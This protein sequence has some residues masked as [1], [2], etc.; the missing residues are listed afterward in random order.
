[1]EIQSIAVLGGGNGAHALAA[2]LALQGYEVYMYELPEFAEKFQ[3]TLKSQS[4]S[5]APVF[6]PELPEKYKVPQG[7]AR[8]KKATTNIKEALE[9][10][11]VIIV[12][13]PAYGHKAFAETLAP[14]IRDGQIILLTPG[15]LGS[16][17]FRN[18]FKKKGITTNVKIA[19]TAILPYG[20]R[21]TG[22][23]EVRAIIPI[24]VRFAAY[25][26]RD[27]KQ[28]FEFLKPLIRGLAPA[29]N[30]LATTLINGN[31]VQHPPVLLLNVGNVEKMKEV[32]LYRDWTSESV[33]LLM[34]ELD[35][36]KK[37]LCD[38][39]NMDYVM[40]YY[41]VFGNGLEIIHKDG[42]SFVGK[43]GDRYRYG[44]GL[45]AKYLSELAFSLIEG[46]HSVKDR[47]F[48]EDVPF[49]MLPA[50]SLGRFFKIDMPVCESI[51]TLTSKICRQAFRSL[52]RTLAGLGIN[53]NSSEELRSKL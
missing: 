44:D 30:V 36:E 24:E 8:L 12:C 50:V 51:I 11:Q 28:L 26:S 53:F 33:A 6:G 42:L 1:M 22:P 9:K 37:K 3:A 31:C 15:S 38:F 2:D 19:E 32:Y 16:I 14:H 21:M 47:M 29:E 4:I 18:I 23:C 45:G 34:D 43:P 39:L 17:E 27:T 52:G 25:P 35:E 10:A 46:P 20:T 48:T 40:R 49:G 13:C 7:V 41:L 5:I